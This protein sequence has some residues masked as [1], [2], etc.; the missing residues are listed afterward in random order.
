MSIFIYQVSTYL[1]F[2]FDFKD[3]GANEIISISLIGVIMFLFF[4]L[5]CKDP[6]TMK[7]ER[8]PLLKLLKSYECYEVCPF[9]AVY[10]L[11]RSKHCDVC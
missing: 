9:C 2:A 3:I 8:V 5:V 7:K 10:K 1:L 11:P 4:V 6:G